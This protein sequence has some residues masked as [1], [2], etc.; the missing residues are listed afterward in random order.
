MFVVGIEADYTC[1]GTPGCKASDFMTYYILDCFFAF[2]FFVEVILRMV[3]LGPI[4]YFLGDPLSHPSG[5]NGL[6]CVDFCIVFA[7]AVDTFAL[8]GEQGTRIRILSCL[9]VIQIGHLTEPLRLVRGLRE[10]RLIISATPD[11]CKFVVWVMMLLLVLFWV[12]GILLTIAIGHSDEFF[13]YTTSDWNKDDYFGSVPKS[14]FSLFQI[15][16]FSQWSSSLTRP[17]FEVYPWIFIIIVPFIC[18]SSIG[19]LNII[20][21]VVV[22]TTLLSASS[23]EEKEAKELQKTHARVMQSLKL[24]FEEADTDQSGMLD[25]DEL[26]KAMKK[27][28]VRGRMHVLDIPLKD[29]DMLFDTLDED[30]VGEVNTEAFFRGCS[31]L[32]GPALS[33]DM[34]RMSVDFHRYINT[35]DSLIEMSKTT[36]ER[37]DALLADIESVDRDIVRGIVDDVDPILKAR[38]T[39]LIKRGRTSPATTTKARDSIK[40]PEEDKSGRASKRQ[41][42][43]AATVGAVVSDVG[44]HHSKDGDHHH[45]G[46]HRHHG[47]HH[48]K[49][50]HGKAQ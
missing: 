38:R 30:G 49:E 41:S 21:G 34:H 18:I 13:N 16:T 8:Q 26:H 36:N 12:F 15:M 45:H 10:L 33:C 3:T 29:L 7:R 1:W 35:T 6:H 42:F 43:A 50:H 5:I 4:I 40:H 9:R 25:R 28:A 32:R 48:E 20:V 23:H 22:E 17:V 39:R 19:L 11:M 44:Y 27:P 2:V 14:A 37:L 47:E 31:R 46:K 24:V